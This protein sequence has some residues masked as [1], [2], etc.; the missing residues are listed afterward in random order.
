MSAITLN[1]DHSYCKSTSVSKLD[2][3]MKDVQKSPI[4]AQNGVE[5]QNIENTTY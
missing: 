3:T 2:F 4:N 5:L 1:Y